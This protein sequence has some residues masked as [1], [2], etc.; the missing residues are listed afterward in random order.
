MSNEP[1][2]VPADG[3]PQLLL[4]PALAS[5]AESS[6]VCA[7]CWQP[8]VQSGTEVM[9][10]HCLA[11]FL[12]TADEKRGETTRREYGH[13]EVLMGEDGL[14]LEL[15]RGAMGTTYRA[16]DTVL[17]HL[18]ALKVIEQNVAVL[19]AA[20]TRFLREA[21]A[22]ARLRH[23]NVA[24]VFHYGEQEGECFY[25]MELVEGETLEAKM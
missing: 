13:F 25:A 5:A 14:P 1:I 7:T 23:P 19:P 18:V 24:S 15:G 17:H 12:I 21:R 9:C 22:A 2:D 3:R 6:D 4:G 11:G 8:L 20:H 16:R 10:V